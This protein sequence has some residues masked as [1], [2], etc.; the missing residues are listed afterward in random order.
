MAAVP[1]IMA[2]GL[3]GFNLILY[4]YYKIVMKYKNNK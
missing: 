2:I 4:K 1:M 3:Y